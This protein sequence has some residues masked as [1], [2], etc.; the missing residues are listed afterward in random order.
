MDRKSKHWKRKVV[1]RWSENQSNPDAFSPGVY[2]LANP[3]VR[4][5]HQKKGTRGK[6]P[7]W[8]HYCITEFLGDRLPVEKM[9]SVGCGKGALERNL[10]NL[11]AFQHCDAID[12]TPASIES[13]R[14]ESAATGITSI[15]YRV[16]DIEHFDL[17]PSSYDAAWFNGSLHHIAELESVCENI[18][19]ALKSDGYL[20]LQ[21]YI[22]PSRFDFVQRQKEAMRAAFALIPKRYRRCH[23][24]GYRH[25][26]KEGVSLPNPARV[27]RADPSE[28]VR[29]ADIMAVVAE[30][31][32][33]VERNDQ[34][35]TLLQFLLSGIA[36]NFRPEVPDS[37]AVLELLFQVEDTLIETGDLQS[38]FAVVI[39]R[40][41]H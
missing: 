26:Y 38:D 21:E 6:F 20:F 32:Q 14:R 11:G 22:G 7:S 12:L 13:A 15:A 16:A 18:A 27:A 9:L 36:G 1:A 10:A 28:A 34:G 17:T 29:S 31:F 19:R 37:M 8:A 30:Y 35:G 24:P 25:E 4:R 5:R 33:V 3:A 2:W 23:I 40:P 39:A 41:R